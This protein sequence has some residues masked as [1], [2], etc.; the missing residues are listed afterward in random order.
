MGCRSSVHGA[1]LPLLASERLSSVFSDLPKRKTAAVA[2]S[3]YG[4][5]ILGTALKQLVNLMAKN[6]FNVVGAGAF[7]G[8]HSMRKYTGAEAGETEGR[9]DEA[10][11]AVAKEFGALV[12]QK[13]LNGSDISSIKDI[14]SAKVPFKFKFVRTIGPRARKRFLG[15]IEVDANKCSKCSACVKV[16]PV[17]CNPYLTIS[18]FGSTEVEIDGSVN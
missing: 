15:P 7:I 6:G 12:R 13:G 18:S 16:C 8:E 10:D 2:V 5:I 3:V 14:Q 4:D 11:L 17:G 1:R 9:P